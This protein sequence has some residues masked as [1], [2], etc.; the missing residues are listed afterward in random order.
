[1]HTLVFNRLH[2]LIPFREVI[3][4]VHIEFQDG[5][6]VFIVR[7]MQ[8]I[9]IECEHAQEGLT[10]RYFFVVG[11]WCLDIFRIH[12][13]L[14]FGRL[15]FER[16]EQE[17]GGLF[18][19]EFPPFQNLIDMQ[20]FF[21]VILLAILGICPLLRIF[22]DEGDCVDFGLVDEVHIDLLIKIH[23]LFLRQNTD[24]HLIRIRRQLIL[25][26]A[27]KVVPVEQIVITVHQNL[28]FEEAEN[29]SDLP[30]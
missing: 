4:M 7:V 30:S 10:S 11:F 2:D 24:G 29:V 23:T 26:H 28:L 1:M 22:L 3:G 18:A 8:V 16:P 27:D 15:S 12:T 13:F 9:S 14:R 21:L 6:F 19:L 20:Q 5:A 25:I 17:S